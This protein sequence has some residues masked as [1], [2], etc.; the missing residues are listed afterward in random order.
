MV[1][2]IRTLSSLQSSL[3]VDTCACKYFAMSF[4]TSSLLDACSMQR[5]SHSHGAYQDYI[6]E[7]GV[8]EIICTDN[9]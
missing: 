3:F 4:R 5:E 2:P 9:S 8:S 1:K 7:I 6:C